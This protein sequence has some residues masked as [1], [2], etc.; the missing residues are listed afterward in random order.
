MRRSNEY[1]ILTDIRGVL[2]ECERQG[3]T[4]IY[5]TIAPEQNAYLYELIRGAERHC[6]RFRLVPDLGV[7]MLKKQV[8]IDYLEDMPVLSLRREP[9][10]D[11]GIRY[12]D[13]SSI[14]S[15]ARLSSCSSFPDGPA[16]RAGDPAGFPRSCLL[17]PGQIGKN[18]WSFPC[19]KFRSMVKNNAAEHRQATRNDSRVT[20]LGRFLRRTSLDE[21]PQFLNVLKGDMS[22]VGPRPHMLKHTSDYS[23]LLDQ[24]M[25]RQFVKPGITGWAQVNGYRGETRDLAQMEKRIEHDIWYLENWSLWL[26]VRIVFM[27][28][29]IS[30]AAK[31]TPIERLPASSRSARS[32]FPG[33]SLRQVPLI[34]YLWSRPYETVRFLSRPLKDV[35]SG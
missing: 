26:D 20:R 15:S 29:S 34:S 30:S 25:I 13:A 31:P 33:L 27:T 4:E 14:S 17:H 3:V 11:L 24:F 35:I 28:F 10:E 1:P 22:I 23:Q 7:F 16:R 6:I 32:T 19:F 5:S 12:A 18:N 21:F 2:E 8:Y 9:L